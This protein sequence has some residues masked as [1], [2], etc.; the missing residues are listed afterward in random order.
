MQNDIKQVTVTLM[1]RVKIGD[2]WRRIPV[3]Y[4]KTGR[5]IP[6]LVILVGKEYR[7]E[8]VSYENRFYKD[9][10]AC[11]IPAGKNA[12]DAEE[13]RRTLSQQLSA[14]AFALDAGV[15]VAEPADRKK[16]TDWAREHLSDK[17]DEIGDA[18]LRKERYGIARFLERCRKTH[19]DELTRKDILDV[20]SHLRSYPVYWLARKS[21]SKRSQATQIRK[22]LPA[23]HRCLSKRTVFQYYMIIRA[24]LLKGGADKKIFPPPP[25]FEEKTVTI[26]TPEEIAS[27]FSLATG[28][29]RMAIQLMLKCGMRRQEAAHA[30]FNDINYT[31]KTIII[32]GKPEYGFQTKTRKQSI[33]PIPDDLVEELRQWEQDHPRQ[34][35]I[36]Q[37][38]KGKPDLRMIRHLKRFAYLHGLRCGRC[39]HCRSGNPNCE[40]WE[41]HKFRRTYITGICRKVDLRTTQEYAGHTRITST[42]RYLKAASAAEGQKSVSS[43]D[44][45]KP[46]YS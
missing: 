16:L 4:G 45:T 3:T 40:A 42:E 22:R 34:T 15:A 19:I 24:W 35:L 46:H 1:I 7:F 28:H 21:P 38:T 30:Y 14:K 39:S 5:V 13:K 11:Y 27:L 36:I 29:L 10:K 17:A 33:V 6:G 12:S 23:E 37:T 32:R 26:Y 43:I 31:D 9:G 20:L 44:W 41:L 2:K 25:E 18:Q 8:N